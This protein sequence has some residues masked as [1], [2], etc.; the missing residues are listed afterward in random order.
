MT[1]T[2]AP[3]LIDPR[4]G[5]ASAVA[6]GTLAVEAVQPEQLDGPTPCADYDVRQLTHHLV[7]VLRRVAVIGAGGDPFS[8][9]VNDLDVPDAEL[10]AAWAE[11]AE[12][13]ED[14]WRDDEVLG[15]MRTL[16]FA[17]LPGAI[18]LSI[19]TSEVLVHTWDLASAIGHDLPWDAVADEVAAS[20]AAM[21]VALPAEH[22][23]GEIPFAP[24]VEVGADASLIEQLVAWTGRRP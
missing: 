16:P 22:R 21:R 19:Y 23:G 12:H 20:L 11:A 10:P 5:F 13:A 3:T 14:A 8:V 9:T 24:P 6:L 15:A 2:E 17:T 7:G 18:A 4:P 1:N